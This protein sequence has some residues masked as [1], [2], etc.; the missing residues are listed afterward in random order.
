MCLYPDRRP[1][2]GSCRQGVCVCVCVCVCTLTGGL[3]SGLVHVCRVKVACISDVLLTCACV[4]CVLMQDAIAQTLRDRFKEFR[5]P[6]KPRRTTTSASVP[7]LKTPPG[8]T[9]PLAS[10][11]I[12]AG[13]DKVSFQR[14]ANALCLEF[15]KVKPNMSVVDDLMTMSFAMRW[16]DLHNNS[17]DI[18]SVFQKYPFLRM[19][20]KVNSCVCVC[21]CDDGTQ[22]ITFVYTLSSWQNLA[23]TCKTKTLSTIQQ[24]SGK[25]LVGRSL[26]RRS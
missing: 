24:K 2:F 9:S 14:H 3:L 16:E 17:Y 20:D 12:P 23:D 26:L 13:E 4:Y 5:R 25:S 8:I 11:P 15:K 1:A 22:F 19:A 6:K 21:V 10:P 7:L 18:G